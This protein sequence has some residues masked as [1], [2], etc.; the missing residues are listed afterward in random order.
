MHACTQRM[1]PCVCAATLLWEVSALQACMTV[2]ALATTPQGRAMP[3]HVVCMMGMGSEPNNPSA[4]CPKTIRC[5]C[6]AVVHCAGRPLPLLTC[7]CADT[8]HARSPTPCGHAVHPQRVRVCACMCAAE[9]LCASLDVGGL[10]AALDLAGGVVLLAL[11]GQRRR[12]LQVALAW[13]ACRA[14]GKGRGR[15]PEAFVHGLDHAAQAA[16]SRYH[17][18]HARQ[19]TCAMCDSRWALPARPS[20]PASRGAKAQAGTCTRAACTNTRARAHTHARILK[21]THLRACCG[22]RTRGSR[23][24]A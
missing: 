6:R 16:L 19:A 2:P 9:R 3:C 5:C 14:G 13:R 11:L 18:S 7:T 15:G 8:M 23:S 1:Y 24:Q 20:P 12:A 22:P 4:G 17:P 21:I 10:V